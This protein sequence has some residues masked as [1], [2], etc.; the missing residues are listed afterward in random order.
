MQE[1]S[2]RNLVA[3]FEISCEIRIA[4][5]AAPLWSLICQTKSDR[6]QAVAQKLVKILIFYIYMNR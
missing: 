2:T 6:I 5:M 4:T 1:S 3:Q